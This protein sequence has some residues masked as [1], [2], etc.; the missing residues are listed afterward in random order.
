MITDDHKAALT[1]TSAGVKR[2]NHEIEMS[3]I[4]SIPVSST[5]SPRTNDPEDLLPRKKKLSES[6]PSS[7]AVTSASTPAPAIPSMSYSSKRSQTKKSISG[8]SARNS[9]GS[10]TSIASPPSTFTSTASSPNFPHLNIRSPISP[11]QSFIY[12]PPASIDT[13]S[14]FAINRNSSRPHPTSSIASPVESPLPTQMGSMAFANQISVN[15]IGP[16]SSPRNDDSMLSQEILPLPEIQKIIPQT[17]PVRGGID[18]SLFGLNFVD[19]LVPKFGDNN[20]VSTICWS[21]QSLVTQLP[22]S[23]YPGPVIVSFEGLTMPGAQIFSYFDD[24]DRQLIELALR[25]VGVKMNGKLEDARDIARRIVGTGTGFDSEINSFTNSSS[26]TRNHSVGPNN[27]S[28]GGS[29]GSSSGIPMD[30]LEPLLLSLM[31]L[32][33]SYENGITPNWQLRNNEGQVMLHLAAILGFDKF[34]DALLSHNAHTDVQD[35]NGYTPLHFAALHGHESII[36]ELLKHNADPC[37]RTYFG[38][39]YHNLLFGEEPSFSSRGSSLNLTKQQ[40]QEHA[41]PVSSQ[42]SYPSAQEMFSFNDELSDDDED[43]AS[44]DDDEFDYPVSKYEFQFIGDDSSSDESEDDSD[45]D[46]SDDS[47]FA[48]EESDIVEFIAHRSHS[49]QRTIEAVDE[50]EQNGDVINGEHDPVEGEEQPTTFANKLGAYLPYFLR[51]GPGGVGAQ[52]EAMNNAINAL[53]MNGLFDVRQ[54]WSNSNNNSNENSDSESGANNSNGNVVAQRN[55]LAAG[56]AM[57][58]SLFD[59]TANTTSNSDASG[60][61]SSNPGATSTDDVPLAPPNYFDLYPQGSSRDG[62]FPNTEEEKEQQKS[63][64]SSSETATDATSEVDDNT[65]STEEVSENLVK[66]EEPESEDD[67][68]KPTEDDLVEIWRSNRKKLQN[69][70]MFLFFWLPIFIFILVWICYNTISYMDRFDASETMRS[71]AER[72]AKSI[73]S[74]IL[75][76]EKY[77]RYQQKAF[78]AIGAVGRVTTA[79]VTGVTNAATYNGNADVASGPLLQPINDGTILEV[80]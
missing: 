19:G 63:A 16:F 54:R 6:K 62:D 12:S 55:A 78:D 64:T 50:Q 76:F 14:L 25:V 65:A 39:T 53:Y 17:G 15:S 58:W 29:N 38:Q 24:T 52:A 46:Y 7:S 37:T 59:R 1:K 9:K 80:A 5:P 77:Q 3:D 32:V 45:Y 2:H 70:R 41:A 33:D 35:C 13:G 56:S 71:R 68:V 49:T 57:I 42:S 30:R 18:V 44:D 66:S 73:M 28:E 8:R 75:G 69:D 20:A 74:S 21:P 26:N 61:N 47:D 10:I 22:P 79:A 72:Y 4:D 36:S 34:C 43:Y 27:S 60:D 48:D 11:P 23:K 31:D 67:S 40:S 51:P